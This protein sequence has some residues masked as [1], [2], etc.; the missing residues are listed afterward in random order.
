MANKKDNSSPN[1]K[2]APNNY[3][4]LFYDSKDFLYK[5]AHQNQIILLLYQFQLGFSNLWHGDTSLEVFNED[6]YFFK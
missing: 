6:K 4:D 3:E 5:K 2:S 1:Y